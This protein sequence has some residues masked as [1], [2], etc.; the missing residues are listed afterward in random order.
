MSRAAQLLAALSQA[1]KRQFDAGQ[2]D[3]LELTLTQVEALSVQRNTLTMQ[4][5]AQRA[6]GALEDALQ[7]PLTGGPL[8]AWALNP[9][10][11]PDLAQR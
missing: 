3:R 4:T 8:P 2:I 6:L 1:A 7:M 9:P 5:E 11:S 10:P